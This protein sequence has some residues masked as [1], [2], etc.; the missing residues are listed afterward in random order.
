MARRMDRQ[1]HTRE[2]LD[3]RQHGS[4]RLKFTIAT[5]HTH[6]RTAHTPL[7]HTQAYSHARTHACTYTHTHTHACMHGLHRTA[8][9]HT[10]PHACMHRCTPAH[11]CT[12]TYLVTYSQL[13]GMPTRK[14]AGM[15]GTDIHE[16]NERLLAIGD[17]G[18]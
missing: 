3:D 17:S 6:V 14:H 12:R 15:A 7:P 13:T 1:T 4:E 8:P 11:V 10:V 5:W 2:G 9:Q 18:L 16:D